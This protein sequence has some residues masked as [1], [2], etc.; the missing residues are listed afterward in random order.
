MKN[1]MNFMF[2]VIQNGETVQ[3]YETHSK[4]RF[5][6]KIGTINWR[7]RPS[8]VCLRVSYAKQR[9]V[10]GKLEPMYN[11]GEYVAEEDFL[12]A[13]LAFTES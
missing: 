11:D 2:R 8:K 5:H 10:N 7:D 6:N 13:L 3:R 1:K 4:R 9:A 12:H